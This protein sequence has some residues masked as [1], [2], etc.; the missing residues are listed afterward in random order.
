MLDVLFIP[1][2]NKKHARISSY[3]SIVHI[4]KD[5]KYTDTMHSAQ[6]ALNDTQITTRSRINPLVEYVY[7]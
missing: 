5:A 6:R 1:V 7:A 2:K 3:L 4:E